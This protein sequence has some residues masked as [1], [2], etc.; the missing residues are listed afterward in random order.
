MSEDDGMSLT[1]DP[2][3]DQRVTARRL[4]DAY[5]AGGDPATA[6]L[7][8]RGEPCPAWADLPPNI[9]AKWEAAAAVAHS[10]AEGL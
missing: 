6:G 10:V 7:N 9:R 4:Y 3:R 1:H 2:R 5:N 8:Y